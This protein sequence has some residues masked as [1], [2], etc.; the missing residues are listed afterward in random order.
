[1]VEALETQLLHADLEVDCPGCEY[2]IWVTGAEVVAQTAVTC[3][4]CR[5]RTW[6][7]DADGSL[8]NVGRVVEQQINQALRDL[9]RPAGKP[10]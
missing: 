6:V 5:A 4:C 2:P 7:L 9:W 3:P 1:M 10:S 8:Q